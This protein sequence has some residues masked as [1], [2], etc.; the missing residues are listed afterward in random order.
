MTVKSSIIRFAA[1]MGS[2]S[3]YVL[4]IVALIACTIS[5]A[6]LGQSSPTAFGLI[7]GLSAFSILQA[8]TI[9]VEQ[10]ASS[11]IARRRDE[12]LH[13]KIDGVIKAID[14]ADDHLIGIEREVENE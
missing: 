8:S 6:I 3:F 9:L 5:V 1:F 7:Y 10:R 4:T 12:A 2:A 14:K 13:T 11:D